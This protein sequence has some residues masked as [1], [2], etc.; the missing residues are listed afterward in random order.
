MDAMDKKLDFIITLLGG[1]GQTPTKDE[2]YSKEKMEDD[3]EVDGK[4]MDENVVLDIVEEQF[5]VDVWKDQEKG[6]R[7]HFEAQLHV[8]D[9]SDDEDEGN[10]PPEKVINNIYISFYCCSSIFVC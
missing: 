4:K 10:T 7:E 8:D 9:I 6:V 5:H 2:A 3:M 1:K